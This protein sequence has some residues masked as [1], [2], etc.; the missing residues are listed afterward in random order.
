MAR[1]RDGQ[2]QQARSR[3]TR[4][5][6]I[7][8][9]SIVDNGGRGH[10]H[11]RQSIRRHPRDVAGPAK[12]PSVIVGFQRFDSKAGKHAIR[13]DVM[14]GDMGHI[15]TTHS[16]YASVVKAAQPAEQVLSQA[17]GLAATQKNAEAQSHVDST[18]EFEIKLPVGENVFERPKGCRCRLY[19]LVDI[20]L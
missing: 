5:V 6:S 1:I 11:A 9:N 3:D 20:G 4:Q 19:L 12:E 16:A 18:F 13:R 10:G 14:S 15:D 17:P 2:N 7:S 8:Y